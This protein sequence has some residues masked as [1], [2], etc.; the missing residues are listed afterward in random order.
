[1][2]QEKSSATL[3]GDA[4]Q[5]LILTSIAYLVAYIYESSYLRY[6]GASPEFVTI[7]VKTLIAAGI[8]VFVAF[9]LIYQ[10]IDIISTV[11]KN[12]IPDGNLSKLFNQFGILFIPLAILVLISDLPILNKIYLIFVPFPMFWFQIIYPVFE[13][14][15]YGSYKEAQAAIIKYSNPAPSGLILKNPDKG[16]QDYL[17]IIL[18]SVYAAMAA[19]TVGT[20]NA[21]QQE[22]FFYE[23]KK[24]Q[25]LIRAYGEIALFGEVKAGVLSGTFSIQKLDGLTLTQHT[26]D[27]LISNDNEESSL[28]E[29]IK[30]LFTSLFDTNKN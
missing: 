4:L 22:D 11:I 14:K 27:N 24:Q 23:P 28:L 5:V 30:S 25:I 29:R 15:K 20:M 12:S 26:Y 10:V 17:L 2:E 1:M 18:I 3:K 16:V 8:A 19:S 9:S 13:R 7:N 21:S 6:F